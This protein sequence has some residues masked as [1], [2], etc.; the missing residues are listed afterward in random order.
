MPRIHALIPTFNCSESII[1]C[2]RSLDGKV[3]E[4][5]IL[6]GRWI[7]VS[8]YSLH[9]T[10]DTIEKIIEW[11]IDA[12]SKVKLMLAKEQVHQ[13]DARNQ[14]IN[15]VPDGD[16]FL[17]VDSDEIIVKW[18]PKIDENQIGYRIRMTSEKI[19]KEKPDFGLPFPIPRF[20]KKINGI[21]FTR[22][23]R[24]MENND[25]A[26]LI[27]DLP[28]IEILIAN[29][30]MSASKAMRNTMQDYETWLLKWEQANENLK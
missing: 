23:H 9:S 14:L 26:I 15:A 17:F 30:T 16:F 3:D 18:N 10:D 8:G 24:Y 2:L 7:G 28:I 21:R 5:I 11:G 25:G 6:D 4:I 13:I 29:L 22:N 1:D 20:M 19:F 27:G 12:K